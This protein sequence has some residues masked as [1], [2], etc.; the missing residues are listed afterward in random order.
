MPELDEHVSQFDKDSKGEITNHD[1]HHNID[2]GRKGEDAAVKFLESKDFEIIERNWK[3]AA[4]EADII[5]KD[6]EY[7]HFIEV[8]TRMGDGRGFPEES[9]TKKKRRRYE[10]IAEM[11]LQTYDGDDIGITF[12]IIS[13][14]VLSNSRAILRFH[15]NVLSCDCR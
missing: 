3:T 5:A 9:V 4:G 1:N 11:Y 15:R 14:N 7:I 13:I 2:L 12:D 8:K 10:S 6:D